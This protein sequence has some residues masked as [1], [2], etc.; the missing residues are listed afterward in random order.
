MEGDR[1]SVPD[2]ES[3]G[4]IDDVFSSLGDFERVP[5][6]VRELVLLLEGESV[7]LA[8]D[9]LSGKESDS[10]RVG[11]TLAVS[12]SVAAWVDEVDSDRLK[13]IVLV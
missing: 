11:V 5:E 12:E 4:E 1:E 3:G 6:G 9:E 8:E 13:L 2:G 10:E 7:K